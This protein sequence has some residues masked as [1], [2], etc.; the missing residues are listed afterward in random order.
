MMELLEGIYKE[1]PGTR[2]HTESDQKVDKISWDSSC[3]QP[4][5]SAHWT[6][7]MVV[8]GSRTSFLAVFISESVNG[9]VESRVSMQIATSLSIG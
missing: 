4:E 6:A 2:A 5:G 9:T 1:V 7:C 3:M 8:S